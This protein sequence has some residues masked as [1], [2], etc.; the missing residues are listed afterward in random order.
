MR[1]SLDPTLLSRLRRLLRPDWSRTVAARRFAAGILVLLAALVAVRP[2]PATARTDVVVATH[3]LAPGTPLTATDL[4][5]E[6]RPAAT[7]PDGAQSDPA[8]VAGATLAGPARRG[9]ILTD[10]R[11][12]GPR[13]TA[14]TAGPNARLVAVHPADPAVADLVRTGDTVDVLAAAESEAHPRVVAADAVV[15]S[16]SATGTS[17]TSDGDRVVLLALPAPA[18]TAVAA[19]TLTK[20]V[21]LTLH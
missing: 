9:E 7:V 12:L 2:D 11:V 21:T 5:L 20:Q 15:V 14:A 8:S 16:V 6:K 10:V 13:L 19:A 3:D 1:E 17:P 4:Q 18:A